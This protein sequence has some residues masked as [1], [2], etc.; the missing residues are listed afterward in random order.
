MLLQR[1]PIYVRYVV[2]IQMNNDATTEK[3]QKPP[4]PI[5]QIC[6]CLVFHQHFSLMTKLVYTPDV[7]GLVKKSHNNHVILLSSN[8][9]QLGNFFRFVYYSI[10]ADDPSIHRM[11][12]GNKFPIDY[13][14]SEFISTDFALLQNSFDLNELV[15]RLS[16]HF[17]TQTANK[18]FVI[19]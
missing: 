9:N 18:S 16:R 13:F 8:I 6:F 10:G 5:P 15:E 1:N 17:Q 2:V 14:Q 4:K 12:H 11:E 3:P 19:G 7:I